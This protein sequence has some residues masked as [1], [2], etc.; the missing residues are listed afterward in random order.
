MSGQRTG[1]ALFVVRR[2]FLLALVGACLVVPVVAIALN[3]LG[4]QSQ[5]TATQ[6]ACSDPTTPCALPQTTPTG[7]A[8]TGYHADGPSAT[9]FGRLT[10]PTPATCAIAFIVVLC[11]VLA[12]ALR[13]RAR[14][15]GAQRQSG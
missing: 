1:H 6:L 11:V 4:P 2:V 10:H 15:A 5:N 14:H 13:R 12:E 7:R 8:A 9:I 3:T